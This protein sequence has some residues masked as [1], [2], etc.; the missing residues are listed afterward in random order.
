MGD[1]TPM[2]ESNAPESRERETLVLLRRAIGEGWNIPESAF[3]NGAAIAV[4]I[5]ANEQASNRDRC[6][7]LELLTKMRDSNIA[8][9][10]AL[11]KIDRL[12][13]GAATEIVFQVNKIEL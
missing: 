8:A 9:A 12:N 7:A 3:K 13:S 2:G 1:L 11:D 4:R 5:V 10:V 6:R